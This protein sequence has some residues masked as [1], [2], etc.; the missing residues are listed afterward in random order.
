MTKSN[1]KSELITIEWQMGQRKAHITKKTAKK[2]DQ[3]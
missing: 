1:T 3:D 2:P